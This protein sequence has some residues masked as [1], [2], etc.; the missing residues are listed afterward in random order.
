MPNGRY[1]ASCLCQ[2]RKRLHRRSGSSTSTS[3]TPLRLTG[4]SMESGAIQWIWSAPHQQYY[5][6]TSDSANSSCSMFE[7]LSL[8]DSSGYGRIVYHWQS[9]ANV[10][11]DGKIS[12]AVYQPMRVRNDSGNADDHSVEA[13][14]PD[15]RSSLPN[16]I[17][18]T[19]GGAEPLD[20]STLRMA[21]F[22]VPI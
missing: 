11:T 15:I 18:G 13:V 5:Y 21:F 6:A 3:P 4:K 17:T 14:P 22:P 1:I 16:L 19:S 2:A 20:E 12:Q 10:P 7:T 9:D 8:T